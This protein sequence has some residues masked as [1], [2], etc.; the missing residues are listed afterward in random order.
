MPL[1]FTCLS[2]TKKDLSA[3]P[4]GEA[5]HQLDCCAD[6]GVGNDCALSLPSWRSDINALTPLHAETYNGHSDGIRQEIRRIKN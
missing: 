4:L 5:V 1:Q 6:T 3:T 2:E